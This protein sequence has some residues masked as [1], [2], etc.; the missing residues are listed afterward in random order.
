MNFEVP[1]PRP[2]VAVAN[3]KAKAK[4]EVNKYDIS[5]LQWTTE[6]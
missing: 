4:L 1:H 3:C 5:H 6:A 2:T